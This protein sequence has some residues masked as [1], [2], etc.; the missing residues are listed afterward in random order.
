MKIGTLAANVGLNPS[1]IRYYEKIGLLPAPSRASGQRR[2][3]SES[4]DRVLLIKFAG[5][6]GFSLDEIRIFLNGIRETAP[7]G[8]RWKKLAARKIIEL[9]ELIARARRLEKLMRGLS[10]CHCSSLHECV[11]RLDLSPNRRA[12]RRSAAKSFPRAIAS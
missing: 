10:H 1:A 7:V 5:E 9:R 3:S 8:P 12:I 6:M 11:R 2:Y 4:L